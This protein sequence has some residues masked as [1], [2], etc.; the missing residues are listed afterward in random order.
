LCFCSYAS[1]SQL[2]EKSDVY[3]F[4]VVLLEIITGKPPNLQSGQHL[5]QFVQQ[6]LFKGNIESILDPNMGVQ[7]NLNSIW[8]VANLALRCT[9]HPAKRPDMTRIVIELKDS[10]NLEM[11]SFETGSMAS[12]D[13]SQYTGYSGNEKPVGSAVYSSNFEMVHIGAMRPPDYGPSPR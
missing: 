6:R 9:D 10:L 4:G 7:Y 13:N 3:S 1:T 12:G 2:T 8:K 11:S 5:T